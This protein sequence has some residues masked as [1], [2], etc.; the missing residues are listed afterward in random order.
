MTQT[1]L[2]NLIMEAHDVMEEKK[3]DIAEKLYQ[4]ILTYNPNH[5]FVLHTYAN[6]LLE[7]KDY[8]GAI[9]YAMYAIETG[10][11]KEESSNGSHSVI[12][13]SY[14]ALAEQYPDRKEYYMQ[15]A[16]PYLDVLLQIIKQKGFYEKWGFLYF[17][18][19]LGEYV[20]ILEIYSEHDNA[21]FYALMAIEKY[22]QK[23]ESYLLVSEIMML[24][25]SY[26]DAFKL[27]DKARLLEVEN[28]KVYKML[29]DYYRLLGNSEQAKL[30]LAKAE[31]LI[32]SKEESPN[33]SC[34]WNH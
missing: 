20:R 2:E 1:H 17:M 27:I 18:A 5:K 30:S 3:Y 9:K 16:R 10:I 12:G 32:N 31:A 7:K 14:L 28:P 34:G 21:L 19:K 33:H 29:S 25:G 11:D 4:T 24:Q 22:P 26:E 6:M 23:A 13:K 15:Q 8:A